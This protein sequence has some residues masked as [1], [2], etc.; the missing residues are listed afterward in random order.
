MV[1]HMQTDSPPQYAAH[2]HLQLILRLEHVVKATFGTVTQMRGRIEPGTDGRRTANAIAQ[3][4]RRAH[5][6]ASI[7]EKQSADISVGTLAQFADMTGHRLAWLVSGEGPE[8]HGEVAP[9]ASLQAALAAAVE[10][11]VSDIN[12]LVR[13]APAQSSAQERPLLAANGAKLLALILAVARVDAHR[14]RASAIH[15]SNWQ[16]AMDVDRRVA[17]A[18]MERPHLDRAIRVID[19]M[20]SDDAERTLREGTGPLGLFDLHELAIAGDVACWN[21]RPLPPFEVRVLPVAPFSAADPRPRAALVR[22]I[23]N[24]RRASQPEA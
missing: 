20:A 14:Q 19:R 2:A 13:N 4:I 11:H 6:E 22:Q 15:A 8:R 18:S 10:V 7:G 23:S 17:G 21:D 1:A 16:I 9:R 5:R 24:A 12:Q 3:Q